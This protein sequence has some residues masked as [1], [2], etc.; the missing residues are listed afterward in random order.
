MDLNIENCFG[1][2]EITSVTVNKTDTVASLR[3][4]IISLYKLEKID[5]NRIGLSLE[6]K[7]EYS[8][9]EPKKI[10]LSENSKTLEQ[11]GVQSGDKIKLK[12]LGIQINWRLVYVIEYLGPLFI[13]LF[14]F[15]FNKNF[16]NSIHRILL[17]FMSTL[18]YLKR[19]LESMFLHE[20][21]RYTM[22]LK[23]LLINCTYYWGVY[24]LVCGY[25]LF[26]SD[27]TNSNSHF[28]G[29]F[30]YVLVLLFLLSEY[31]NYVCHKIL[32]DLKSENNGQRGIPKGDAF[33]FVSCAN[34]FYE[35]CSWMFF[36]LFANHLSCYVFWIFGTFIMASWANDRHRSYL[37]TFGEKY[38]KNR[39]RI[40]PFIY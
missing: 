1:N 30:K 29:D 26:L 31:K 40:I 37:K 17:F 2:K 32:K 10:F 19:V 39:K 21:S 5:F 38:P 35:S 34:Y 28:L 12:D 11:Y 9:E 8:L 20:F 36:S 23:N 6:T 18:H 14:M 4:T 15:V 27:S 13:V 33:E 25:F 7:K 16:E 3:S 24:G 22:P